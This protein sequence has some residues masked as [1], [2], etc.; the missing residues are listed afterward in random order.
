G[1]HM[2]SDLKNP[3]E[4]IQAEAY[5][6]MSGIQTEGTDDD[7]GGDNIGWINDGDWVKYERVHFERDASSIEV[8]VASDTPGGRIEIR[9]GSPTGTLLGDVQVP[10]TG[11]WQQWQTVTGNVQIQP[12]TYDV[13]LV[14]KGSPEYDLMN[15]NWFV[16]RANG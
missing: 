7:G 3:Y 16:F 11:G 2:A 1:S 5:D 15:V 9:T 4:R 13:Y 8:R 6:A 10:N 14:F 12:G